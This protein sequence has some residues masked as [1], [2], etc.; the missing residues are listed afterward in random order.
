MLPNSQFTRIFWY[1]IRSYL[2]SD[3]YLC[4]YGNCSISVFLREKRKV[5]FETYLRRMV[6]RFN[7]ELLVDMHKVS[8]NVSRPVFVLLCFV[9]LYPHLGKATLMLEFQYP[10]GFPVSL[11]RNPAGYQHS[12]IRVPYP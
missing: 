6:N 7:K 2:Y 1:Y 12:R 4:H 5:E 3:G 9:L 10:A 8:F 11:D